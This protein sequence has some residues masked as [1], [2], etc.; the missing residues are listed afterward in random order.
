[1]A[2][3]KKSS[4]KGG[5]FKEKLKFDAFHRL[6]TGLIVICFMVVSVASASAGSSAIT[7][8]Y[9][10]IVVIVILQLVGVIIIRSWAKWEEV[11]RGVKPPAARK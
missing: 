11:R 7:T 2:A 1:M 4:A 10:G 5:K 8:M 6:W 9:R 3:E